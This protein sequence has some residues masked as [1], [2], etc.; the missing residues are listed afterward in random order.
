MENICVRLKFKISG[1]K[2]PQKAD[3]RNLDKDSLQSLLKSEA[4]GRQGFWLRRTYK[5]TT[6]FEVLYGFLSAL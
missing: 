4:Y 3:T 1:R 2:S 5:A 6:V